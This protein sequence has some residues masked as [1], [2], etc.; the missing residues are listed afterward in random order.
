MNLAFRMLAAGLTLGCLSF[1]VRAVSP[2]PEDLRGVCITGVPG[3]GG[4]LL[5]GRMLRAGEVL[6]AE[7]AARV[8]PVSGESGA[9]VRYLPV[10]D[11]GVEPPAVIS[12]GRR[13]NQ[14]P[15]ALDSLMETYQNLPN[16]HSLRASDPEGMGVGEILI[17]LHQGIQ[18][19][20]GLI[21][22]PPH[23]NHRRGFHPVVG[24]RQIPD[25]SARFPGN[26]DHPCGLLCR[27]HIPGPEH[28]PVQQKSSGARNPGDADPSEILREGADGPDGKTQTAES[29]PRR[30]HTKCQIHACYLQ[31]RCR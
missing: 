17:G 12:V 11:H 26:G 20:R 24:Y 25:Q 9:L 31:K 30:Q 13:D 2:F 27:Q 19:L 22:P 28:P 10:S 8:V 21:V 5:D 4:L 14:A 18:G 3:S 16:T 6:T 1:P 23:R 7:Q 29:Q 15:E